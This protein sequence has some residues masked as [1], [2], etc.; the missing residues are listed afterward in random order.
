VIKITGNLLKNFKYGGVN[1]DFIN[2]LFSPLTILQTTPTGTPAEIAEHGIQFFDDWI[3]RVGGIVAFIGAI[4]LALAIR[5]E[6]ITEKIQ[7]LG[8]LISGFLII[9]AVTTLDIFT[10]MG[11]AGADA[12]FEAIMNHIATWTTYLGCTVMLFGA[13]NIAFAMRDLNSG[14]AKKTIALLTFASGAIV[15]GVSQSLRLFV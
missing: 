6:E 9:S 4:K 11:G 7:A 3:Q 5:T 13:L 1:M 15:I 14:A 8:I 12:E 2:Y 10:V